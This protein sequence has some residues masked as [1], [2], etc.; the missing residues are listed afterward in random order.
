MQLWKCSLGAID[1][2]P[3]N[4]RLCFLASNPRWQ[5]MLQLLNKDEQICHKSGVGE[6]GFTKK[7]SM[8]MVVDFKLEHNV[9]KLVMGVTVDS[10]YSTPLLQFLFG[11][12]CC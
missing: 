7:D 5:D 9:T 4:L 6:H 10:H 2:A 12:N 1:R 11:F 3:Q 8:R